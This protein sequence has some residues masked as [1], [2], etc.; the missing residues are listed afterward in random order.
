M[1]WSHHSGFAAQHTSTLQSY[2]YNF[3]FIVKTTRVPITTL[4]E[5]DDCVRINVHYCERLKK[6][7]PITMRWTHQHHLDFAA[8]HLKSQTPT[9]VTCNSCDSNPSSN[10][11]AG[12]HDGSYGCA[13]SIGIEYLQRRKEKEKTMYLFIHKTS[14]WKTDILLRGEIQGVKKKHQKANS[15]NLKPFKNIHA[16]IMH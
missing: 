11:R 4:V 9:V 13:I 7:K 3:N 16:F 2:L 10:H 14:T 6:V 15:L 8:Q 12:K 5:L 1:G